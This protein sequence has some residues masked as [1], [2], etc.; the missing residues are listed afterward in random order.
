MQYPLTTSSR[1]VA[2]W[3]QDTTTWRLVI[4]LRGEENVPASNIFK[5]FL[6]IAKSHFSTVISVRP[7]VGMGLLCCHWKD[8]NVACYLI[9]FR[10]SVKNIHI[11]LNVIRTVGTLR[12]VLRTFMVGSRPALLGVRNIS[13]KI[14]RKYRKA[15]FIFNT[16]S[17]KSCLYEIMWTNMVEPDRRRMIT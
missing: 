6:K 3:T 5:R 13:Y 15:R 16:F 14:C 4:R 1:N 11:L 9:A 10:K 8:F 2:A 7:S 12:K 17:R